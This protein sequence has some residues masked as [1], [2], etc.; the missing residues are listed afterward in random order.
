[1]DTSNALARELET[2]R[3]PEV[4]MWGVI[5]A[6]IIILA[7]VIW[8]TYKYKIKDFFDKLKKRKNK[9]C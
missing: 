3:N 9:K 2:I 7:T 8:V 4:A 5:F 6:G 1:M